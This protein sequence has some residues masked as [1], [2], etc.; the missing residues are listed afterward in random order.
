MQ[1]SELTGILLMDKP[2][3]FTSHDVVAK[4]RGILHTR[5][6]GHGG[7]LDPLA[8]GVL[9]VFVGGA[10]KAADFAA[11]QD[12]EYVAGFTLGYCTDT[13][14]AT[15]ETLQT[16]GRRAAREDVERALA[17]F[18]GPQ[19]QVPPMYSA[20]KVNGQKLY[21]LARK[22]KEV[23]R[24]ARDII[25]HE[26]VLLDFDEA[27]QKGTLRLTVS[28]GTYVRT[29]INDLGEALGTLA[30]MHSLVRTRSGAYALDQCRSFDE[31]ERAMQDGT[32]LQLMLPT[33]SLFLEHPA[34]QLTG[35][36]AERI[37]RGAVVFPR[38]A[39]GLPEQAGALCRVYHEGRFLMLGQ[40]RELD[41]GGLGLFVFKNFR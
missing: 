36:G 26:A 10:T 1:N 24:P 19:Q 11:A 17:Q 30:V 23:E 32:M 34:V 40:V 6:I 7:T 14:D 37:A 29:I 31:V 27:A 12:K 21:D 20:V 3:G 18:R 41:K 9:P 16:S 5:K 13:Q 28:K 22:G 35:E 25:V 8:T 33:D 2:Q 4:L 15:G 38:Q 39:Q